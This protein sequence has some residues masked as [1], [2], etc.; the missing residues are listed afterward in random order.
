MLESGTLIDGTYRLTE[1]MGS[2][3][4]GAV[5]KAYHERLCTYVVLKQIKDI[6]KG[7]RGGTDAPGRSRY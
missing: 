5:Y 3:C 4:G 7:E 6:A 2:G 1:E